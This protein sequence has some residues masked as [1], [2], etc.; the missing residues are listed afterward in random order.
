MWERRAAPLSGLLAA[1]LMVVSAVLV[2]NFE[3][4]PPT[5]DVSEFYDSNPLRIMV[6][7]YVGLLAAFFVLWFSGTVGDW[8]RRIGRHR[9]GSLIVGGGAMSAAMMTL[10]YLAHTAGAERTRI[11]DFLDPDVAA[12]W[13]DL[14]AFTFGTGAA[15]GLAAVVGGY[16]LARIQSG[17]SDWPG[18]TS[19]VIGVGLISPLNYLAVGLVLLWLPVVSVSLFREAKDTESSLVLAE[20]G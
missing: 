7:S 19:V 6:G 20:G 10:G 16:G 1:A 2:N 4:M 18:I 11:R 3:F 17:K 12:S 8:A 5:E 14:A 9:L 15:L 13:H